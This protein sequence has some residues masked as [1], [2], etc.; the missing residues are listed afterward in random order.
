[1]TVLEDLAAAI[2][3]VS[4]R[5]GPSV[6]GI[7]RG[8]GP[9]C[10]LLVGE[11]LVLTNAH[12][13]REGPPAITLPDGQVLEGQ[14]RGVDIDHDLAV[15]ATDAAPSP[16]EAHGDPG[17]SQPSPIAWAP[18]R[19]TVGTPVVALANPGGRG[20]RAT[21][22][23]V[24]AVDQVFRGPRGRRVTGSLEHTAPLAKGSSGGPV[25]DLEGRLLGIN[26]NRLGEGFYLA[27]PADAALRARLDALAA[28]SSPPRRR[29]GVTL[30]PPHVARRL[31]A[32]VGLPDRTGL[33]VRGVVE[34]GPAERGGLR[35]GDLI[36]EVAGRPATSVDVLHEALD[37]AGPDQP[38]ALRVVRGTEE[39]DL[40]VLVDTTEP[41][42]GDGER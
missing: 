25:V 18:S 39:L 37:A 30:A 35:A 23:L 16:E 13:L 8:W 9:G 12:N 20:L 31:R 29:L 40:A 6:V 28:G 1:M 4:A 27:I 21:F 22:G 24:S 38:L 2:S 36:V 32:A 42:E 17:A 19:A 33:L 15:I 7:G 3:S 41:H 14:A 10:G 34:G 5:V 11:G 26:V